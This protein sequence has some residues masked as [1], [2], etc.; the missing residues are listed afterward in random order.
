MFELAP[1]GI[2]VLHVIV[3]FHEHNQHAVFALCISLL[4]VHLLVSEDKILQRFSHPFFHFI[5]C[6]TWI[7]SHAGTLTNSE[8]W[9]FLLWHDTDAQYAQEDKHP[10]E[11]DH[12]VVVAHGRLYE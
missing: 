7:N 11:Q 9:H 4:L 8:L 2:A 12:D 6:G 10:H 1:E 3:E 5:G